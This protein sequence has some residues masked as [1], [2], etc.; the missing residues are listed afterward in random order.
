VRPRR[1]GPA[2]GESVCRQSVAAFDL[3]EVEG[4]GRRSARRAQ[5]RLG[6]ARQGGPLIGRRS[7]RRQS[8]QDIEKMDEDGRVV[9]ARLPQLVEG[10]FDHALDVRHG[11]D[12]PDRAVGIPVRPALLRAGE[13]LRQ[14]GAE[15]V[16][17]RLR[18]EGVVDPGRERPQADLDEM[19]DRV[20]DVLGR[21]A[22]GAHHDR[23]FDFAL[24]APRERGRGRY[25]ERR[26][27][28]HEEMTGSK[29]QMQHC[30][31]ASGR[32]DQPGEGDG[33]DVPL[34]VEPDPRRIG[35][36][37]RGGDAGDGFPRQQSVEGGPQI[38]S[39]PMHDVVAH[40]GDREVVHE[41][42][43]DENAAEGQRRTER[44][45]EVGGCGGIEAL[46]DRAAH[47][48]QIGDRHRE[49]AEDDLRRLVRHEAADEAGSELACGE[50]EHDHRDGDR[51]RGHRD[52][53]RQEGRHQ[54]ARACGV[55]AEHPPASTDGLHRHAGLR[56]KRDVG[57]G[58]PPEAHQKGDEPQA[59]AQREPDVPQLFH[60][61]GRA[62][63]RRAEPG[64]RS[65]GR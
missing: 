12:D 10:R 36:R 45:G 32:I 63:E 57:E 61:G 62:P 41:V 47:E 17:H 44:D 49:Y 55:A 15:V 9:R 50:R 19:P 46:D 1:G 18:R 34:L 52:H 39:D 65:A 3:V 54:V 56:R 4:V 31:G 14:R 53:R 24:E 22:L 43:Q 21:R 59:S 28:T 48:K 23:A 37:S 13:D 38:A 29:L 40:Q 7:V 30:V 60:H 27:R 8:A 2:G 58:E 35:C 25:G 20:L 11:R 6:L 51:E 26:A 42:E 5:R 33:L 64:G 16:Q